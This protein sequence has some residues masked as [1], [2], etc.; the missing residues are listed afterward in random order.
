[1]EKNKLEKIVPDTSVIISGVLTDL[2][3]RGEVSGEIIIPEFVVEELRAQA[4]R[5]REIGFK[6][7]SEVKKIREFAEQGKIAIKKTERRQT[8]EEIKLAKYGRIDA[9][10]MDVAKEENAS[11]YT[12]DIVQSMVAEAEGIKTKYFKPYEKKKEL[13]LD[14]FFTEDTMSVHLKE[15]TVPMAKRG[16]P[17]NFK[18]VKVGEKISAEE[19]EEII[20]EIEDVVR[21]EED[22]FIEI[23]G[24]SAT[25]IQMGNMR[26]AICRPPFSD[27]IEVT[28]VRPIV[29]LSLDDYK[30]SE[31][32][33]ERLEKKAE[34][35][36]VAG[37]P[38][39]GKST[40]AASLAEFYEK[41]GAI[42]K[43]LES[44]RD[45]Q[46][47]KEITQYT[48]L[49]GSFEN[50]ADLLLLVRPDYTVFDEVRK[51]NDFEIFSDMRLAGIGMIGV[52]HATDPVDAVQ[53]FIGRVELGIIPHIIDTIIYIKAGKIDKVLILNLVV[54]TPTGM[55]EADL[56]RPIVE[57]RD[58]ETGKLEYEIYT[59][60]EENVIIPVK[61]KHDNAMEK[62]AK[63]AIFNEIK[64]FDPTALIEIS[65]NKATVYVENDRIPI[66]IGKN[67]K[68]VGQLEEKLGIKIDI[69]PKIKTLGNEVKFKKEESG[70]YLI[71]TFEKNMFGKIANFYI[72]DEYIFSAT[73]GKT[74]QIRVSKDSDIGKNLIKGLVKDAVK[75]F[76]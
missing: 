37:P 12:A 22:A 67:G 10:I 16:K 24:R 7:L 25:V 27:G 32:L 74:G 62:L 15:D 5:G 63:K 19:L 4:S 39:S 58:F 21:Y 30:L 1:M 57:V 28:A 64:R 42:V 33:K 36:L 8:L 43:T 76:V 52:V 29:K 31:K 73:I 60:G 72:D 70:A 66:I 2:I 69:S 35:I 14:K 23:G 20:K 65:E 26:I 75:V 11:L 6:G 17:G 38:G 34:G 61:E 50:T 51:T 49:H 47:K 71:F 18:L 46:V 45:L 48:K 68:T 9:L 13:K 55:T 56:A 3:E 44:P 53:R 54:R 41:N 40:F 59:Y